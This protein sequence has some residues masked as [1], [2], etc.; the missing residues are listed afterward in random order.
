MRIN[1]FALTGF[2]NVALKNL[3][4]TDKIEIIKLYTREE[5]NHFPYYKEE[6]IYELAKKNNI[7]VEFID[8][9]NDWSIDEESDLNLV[10]TFHR[11]FKK[12]HLKTS[13][14]N[15]NI[16]PSLLPSYKGPTPTNWIIHN[17]EDECGITAHY[18]DEEIDCGMIIYQ[19]SYPQKVKTDKELRKFLS[20][21]VED[22]IAFIIANYCNYDIIKNKYI[23]SYY[24]HYFK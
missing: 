21:K 12:S 17:N 15:L 23:E 24:P 14:V 10:V 9:K 5:K 20:Q 3:L 7:K 18:L 19:K 16:H 2:G 8:H 4:S 13:K 1:L 22:V 11:I 6:P